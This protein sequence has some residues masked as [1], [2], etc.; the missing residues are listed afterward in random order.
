MSMDIGYGIDILP[1]HDPWID[2]SH[3]ANGGLGVASVPGSYW[4]DSFPFREC[5]FFFLCPLAVNSYSYGCP[6]QS[7]TFRPGFLAQ[8]SNAKQRCGGKRW[9]TW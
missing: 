9:T 2:A 1:E 3:I 7:N 4:V 8:G 5:L 6:L